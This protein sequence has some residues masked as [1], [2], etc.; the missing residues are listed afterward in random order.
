MLCDD[1]SFSI[2]AMHPLNVYLFALDNK[3]ISIF[4][5]TIADVLVPAKAD[6][7]LTLLTARNQ[8]VF[9]A[10]TKFC[11]SLLCRS[12]MQVCFSSFVQLEVFVLLLVASY[13]YSFIH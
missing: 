7:F 12:V 8:T 3:P 11:S 9:R 2:S 10:V 13:Y 4:A 6:K 5:L 1:I